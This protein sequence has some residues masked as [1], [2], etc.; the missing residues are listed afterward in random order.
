METRPKH[1][2]NAAS[3]N[4]MQVAAQRLLEHFPEGG[5]FAVYGEM[6]AGKTTF[7]QCICKA[8]NLSFEGSPTFSLVNEYTLANGQKL[9]HFDLYR[10]NSIA[11]LRGIGFDEYLDSGH[12]IFVEWPQ[13]AGVYTDGMKTLTITDVQGVRKIEF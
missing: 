13:I 3:L 4:E 12:Y 5:H 6:G 9:F 1:T 10:V 11:E 7:I 8:L 2:L